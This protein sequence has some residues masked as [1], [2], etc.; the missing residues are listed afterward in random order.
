MSQ[1]PVPIH[2]P[3][4]QPPLD[5]PEFGDA[6]PA[7]GNLLKGS[8][9]FLASLIFHMSLV[10][11]LALVTFDPPID[12]ADHAVVLD[13]VVE[14]P[15]ER[16]LEDELDELEHLATEMSITSMPSAVSGLSGMAPASLAAPQL[17]TKLL[18]DM[19][20]PDVTQVE[21]QLLNKP[22]DTLMKE[23]PVGTQ[24]VANV[25][26]GD[27]NE[28]MDRL[29]QEL[30]WMLDKG[31]VAVVWLFDQSESMKDDQLKIRQRIHRVYDEL[32]L[33]GVAK[34]EALTTGVASYGSGF[35]LHTRT[36]TSNREEIDEAIA[37]VPVDPSGE[38][39]TCQAIMEA[40]KRHRRYAQISKRQLAI[41]LVT[42]ESGNDDNNQRY[43]EEAIQACR[44]ADSRVYVLGR[45]AMFGYPE[46]Q[47]RWEDPQNGNI[48]LLPID[49]GPETAIV[50]QLQT[51][52]FGIRRDAMPSGYGPYEQVRLA[53]ETGGI[54]FMLP[55][56]EKN[57]NELN[58]RRYDVAAMEPYRPDLRPRR[59]QMRDAMQDPLQAVLSKVIYDLN[60]YEASVANVIEIRRFFSADF[61]QLSTQVRMEQAKMLTYID[62]LD[63]AIA[64]IEKAA[65]LRDA[66][67][68]VRQQANYD[69]LYAQLLAYRVRAYEYGAYVTEFVKNPPRVP[70]PPTPKHEFRGWSL[71]TVNKLSAESITKADIEHSREL[72]N[73]IIAEHPGT[74]WASRAKWELE[75]G[76]GIQL[77]PS[78][79]DTTRFPRR[80]GNAPAPPP[81]PIPKL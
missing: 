39:L 42:D 34:D 28:A 33:V 14:E 36:P 2:M 7:S 35:E 46:A 15:L 11:L 66:S 1:A 41:V 74:P 67:P 55:G 20:G 54:F 48:H 80:R 4:G 40:V 61:E 25:V 9:S 22:N 50:E 47:V 51:D 6:Q 29:T 3:A 70:Q 13:D 71:D 63:K 58:D 76:F 21:M 19:L 43:L 10:I 17:E 73:E 57:I 64:A 72:L 18:E 24:G 53:K 37:E 59:D 78:F 81:T 26:V 52:G 5:V 27:Y 32:G 45:E 23:L 44:R 75:R 38:E 68:N 49:R 69:L 8:S 31:E 30:V 12:R 56:E 77:V 65:P 79:F 16:P 60:P 62:Y